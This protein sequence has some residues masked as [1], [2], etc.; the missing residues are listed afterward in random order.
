MNG[1]SVGEK[2]QSQWSVMNMAVYE[3]HLYISW[4]IEIFDPFEEIC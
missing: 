3:L 4:K 2:H 1:V